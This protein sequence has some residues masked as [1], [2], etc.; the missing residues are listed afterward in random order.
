MLYIANSEVEK[1][2]K[3]KFKQKVNLISRRLCRSLALISGKLNGH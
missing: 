2:A 3:L 1:R